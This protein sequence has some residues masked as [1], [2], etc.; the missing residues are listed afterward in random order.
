ME[1]ADPQA[2]AKMILE[3]QGANNGPSNR[4]GSTDDSNGDTYDY[5]TDDPGR[6]YGDDA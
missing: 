2:Y 4:N 1:E 6:N 5:G 3:Q